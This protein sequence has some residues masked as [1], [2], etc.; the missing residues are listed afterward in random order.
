MLT[1]SLHCKLDVRQ[2]SHPTRT[3]I[4]L[5]RSFHSI[6]FS[7]IVVYTQ[8]FPLIVTSLSS[9]KSYAKS[10]VNTHHT[11]IITMR[12]FTFCDVM[13]NLHDLSS[14]SYLVA[15]FS[16][17]WRSYPRDVTLGRVFKGLFLLNQNIAVKAVFSDHKQCYSLTKSYPFLAFPVVSQLIWFVTQSKH[18]R[19]SHRHWKKI[20]LIR[21]A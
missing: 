15:G 2:C 16:D 1:R 7:Y 13:F 12:V 6:L 17:R 3:N 20:M 19:S 10:F 21:V 5:P 11:L 9:E 4:Y 8:E 14:L 18:F